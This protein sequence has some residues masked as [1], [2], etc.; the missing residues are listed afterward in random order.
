MRVGI[1]IRGDAPL[2]DRGRGRGPAGRRPA[3]WTRS[4]EAQLA[5]P[6]ETGISA[7]MVA[8]PDI[9]N[10]DGVSRAVIEVTLRDADGAPSSERAGALLHDAPDVSGR[11]R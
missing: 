1:P 7:Q 11:A 6:S 9:V 5:G 4:N 10:A 8:L 3:G 2:P